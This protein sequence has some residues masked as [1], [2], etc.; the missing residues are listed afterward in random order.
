MICEKF[1]RLYKQG[2]SDKE[3]AAKLSTYPRAI[4][5]YRQKLG[6]KANFPK[7]SLYLMS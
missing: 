3:I 2:L 1:L 5:E 4:W 7:K 6:L